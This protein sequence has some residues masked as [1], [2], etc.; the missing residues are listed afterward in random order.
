[1]PTI[2]TKKKEKDKLTGC[3]QSLDT[4]DESTVYSHYVDQMKS[5][6]HECGA[7]MFEQEK[8]NPVPGN[9]S[10]KNIFSMLCIWCY[11]TTSNQRTSRKT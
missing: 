1:M 7:L 6:C 9:T 8:S 5:S 10:Q 3:C 11:Q 4:F 2:L